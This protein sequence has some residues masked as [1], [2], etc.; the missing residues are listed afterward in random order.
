MSSPEPYRSIDVL[1]RQ[2]LAPLAETVPP[3]GQWERL[4]ATI[5]GVPSRRGAFAGAAHILGTL[6]AQVFQDR[7]RVWIRGLGAFH[8]VYDLD[9]IHVMPHGGCWPSPIAAMM[10]KSVWGLRLAS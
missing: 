3:P 8:P 4:A 5:Q 7:W 2:A 1:F 6:R 9:L 10:V